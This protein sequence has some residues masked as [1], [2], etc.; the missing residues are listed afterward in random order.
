MSR[1]E[2]LE[3]KLVVAFTAS[4]ST[5]CLVSTYR[6]RSP[7]AAVTYDDD[8]YRRLALWWGVLPL[9]SAVA[10]S[11]DE[12]VLEAQEL[13]KR[14]EL[15]RPGDVVLMVGGQSHTAGTTNMIRCTPSRDARAGPR[16]GRFLAPTTTTFR[17]RHPGSGSSEDRL[18][19]QPGCPATAR[20]T[21]GGKP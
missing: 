18:V 7:I 11:T 12:M 2:E 14:R 20:P 6:P 16:R 17:R 8:T 4:G 10:S 19:V 3:C 9:K 21:G 5:A 15:A 13:L 1:A